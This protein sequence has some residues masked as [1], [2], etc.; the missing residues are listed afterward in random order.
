MK[1]RTDSLIPEFVI[2]LAEVRRWSHLVCESRWA[3]PDLIRV[4]CC[5]DGYDL[6]QTAGFIES[7]LIWFLFKSSSTPIIR[8][9]PS[10]LF[11]TRRQT[12][13]G[14][15]ASRCVQFQCLIS[16]ELDREYFA[17]KSPKS[18]FIG[19]PTDAGESWI[20]LLDQ[21][22]VGILFYDREATVIDRSPE[23]TIVGGSSAAM[24]PSFT[25]A[26]SCRCLASDSNAGRR[27]PQILRGKTTQSSG[28]KPRPTQLKTTRRQ[29]NPA[30]NQDQAGLWPASWSKDQRQRHWRHQEDVIS[31]L[32]GMILLM[33]S[34]VTSA[35][36]HHRHI[37]GHVGAT[38]QCEQPH[39]EHDSVMSALTGQ[40]AD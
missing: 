16:E 1:F 19:D 8:S 3:D 31:N 11:A 21:S 30:K 23:S 22:H 13:D 29:S 26:S 34:A 14:E 32:V 25:A 7:N 17:A 37:S 9:D 10:Y 28:L 39:Q 40:D 36:W 38:Q 12:G 33:T 5:W 6:D 18:E 20:R 2:D 35:G 27:R 4:F 24:P 15:D